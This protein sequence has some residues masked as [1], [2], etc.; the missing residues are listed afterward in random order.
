MKLRRLFEW[1]DASDVASQY[2]LNE[3]QIQEFLAIDIRWNSFVTESE[4]SGIVETI[5]AELKLYL[6]QMDDTSA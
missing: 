1:I 4:V 3:N 5:V 2:G 6:Q